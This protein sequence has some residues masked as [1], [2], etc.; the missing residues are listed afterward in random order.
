MFGIELGRKYFYRT[1]EWKEKVHDFGEVKE[2][3]TVPFV[4]EYLGD[5]AYSH[6]TSS[7]GCTTGKWED[8]KISVVY[9]AGNV[10]AH[11]KKEQ[12]YINTIKKIFVHFKNG[13]VDEL[14]LVGKVVPA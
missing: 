12:G 8:N 1:M 3:E 11:V 7:C 14:R 9:K 6:H 4:F 5:K 13:D 10:P 2:G